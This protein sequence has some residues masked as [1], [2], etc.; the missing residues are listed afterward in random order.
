MVEATGHN[1]LTT[2]LPTLALQWADPIFLS[3]SAGPSQ[4]SWTAC[5]GAQGAGPVKN[6]PVASEVWL[7]E[8]L[9]LFKWMGNGQKKCRRKS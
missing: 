7:L 3:P 1:V 9:N 8:F 5:P 4:V 6:K 2:S